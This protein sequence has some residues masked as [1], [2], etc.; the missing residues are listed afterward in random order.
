[1]TSSGSGQMYF[2]GY[3]GQLLDSIEVAVEYAKYDQVRAKQ[4]TKP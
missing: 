1:M 3:L 2:F 4:L